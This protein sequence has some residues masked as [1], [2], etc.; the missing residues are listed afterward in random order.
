VRERSYTAEELEELHQR[1]VQAAVPLVL[2]IWREM[3]AERPGRPEATERA[4]QEK[5]S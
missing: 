4:E 1:Q 3:L 2:R 5:A